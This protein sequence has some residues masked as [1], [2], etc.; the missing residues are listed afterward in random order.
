MQEGLRKQTT[1]E[2]VS[3]KFSVCGKVTYIS[4]PRFKSTND[5]KG[6]AFV[7]FESP[8]EAAKA[9]E[10]GVYTIVAC[11]HTHVS[12]FFFV[13]FDLIEGAAN[14]VMVRVEY[15][16]AIVAC[17]HADVKEFTSVAL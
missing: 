1:H 7:E 12:R 14:A 6:F 8:E 15:L 11:L 10:V 9:I 2:W 16:P 17:L 13:E 4:L 3:R 5:I